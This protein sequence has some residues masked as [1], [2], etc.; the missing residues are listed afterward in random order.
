MRFLLDTHL[1]VWALANSARVPRQVRDLI[2]DSGN[3]VIFSAVSVWELAIK[4]SRGRGDLVDPRV[5]RSE[6][7]TLGYAELPVTSEHSLAIL[8]LPLLHNDPFHRILIAQAIAE[9]ITL[10]TIDAI[11]AQYPGPIRRV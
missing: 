6:L 2:E 9:G 4:Y 7:L 1:L 5:F 10:L 3:E 11:I 8:S